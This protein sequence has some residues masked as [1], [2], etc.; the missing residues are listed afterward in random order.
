MPNGPIGCSGIPPIGPWGG[1]SEWNWTSWVLVTSTEND[2][3]FL[4]SEDASV[5]KP[6]V[7][8]LFNKKDNLI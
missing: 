8:M 4:E 1:A 6:F 7:N 5:W 2:G 3:D